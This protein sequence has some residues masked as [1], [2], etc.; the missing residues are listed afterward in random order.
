MFCEHSILPGAFV[1]VNLNNIWNLYIN[2]GTL[3]KYS[4][5]NAA[6]NITVKDNTL[7]L[8]TGC[9]FTPDS[10]WRFYFDAG[11]C[12][13]FE[14]NLIGTMMFDLGFDYRLFKHMKVGSELYV[15]W[16]DG[17]VVQD[18][19]SQLGVRINWGVLF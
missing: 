14:D 19:F 5:I 15:K 12:F 7:F 11:N 13:L 3:I 2:T 8:N 10:F 9:I 6:P 18:S 4:I 16:S 17:A 1:R